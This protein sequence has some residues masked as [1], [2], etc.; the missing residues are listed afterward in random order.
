MTSLWRALLATVVLAATFLGAPSAAH[1]AALTN[2]AWSVS[3]AHPSEPTTATLSNMGTDLTGG[4]TKWNG[5][6]LAN[7]GTIYGIPRD[8]NQ[9]LIIDPATGT[10]TRSNMGAT[11]SGSDKWFDG[12]LA[13]N[14]KIY[15]IPYDATDILII[16]PV[17]GTAT[18]SNMG[19]TLTEI[20]K[21]SGGVLGSDGKIYGIP[22]YATD[23][24]VI[25][26]VANTATRTAMGATRH[27]RQQVDRW[28]YRQ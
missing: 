26:P 20:D 7:D 24:L 9:I 19:A 28:G 23:I 15:A 10:A 17:T 2:V 8:A 22:R 3:N 6:V 25:D 13:P 11:L 4:T 5:G 1:A 21:W 16:D 18:R 27:G 12:V 14:G